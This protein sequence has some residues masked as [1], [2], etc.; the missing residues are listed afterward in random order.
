[1]FNPKTQ[2]DGYD[3][4]TDVTGTFAGK[5]VA[6]QYQGPYDAYLH[7]GASA[8]ADTANHGWRINGGRT[9]KVSIDDGDKLFARGV[10]SLMI[11]EAV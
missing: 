10:G 11:V 6:V 8:P 5:V 7:I 4:W 1:M 9:E 2:L 3:T